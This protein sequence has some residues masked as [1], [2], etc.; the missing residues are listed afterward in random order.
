MIK[1]DIVE[2]LVKN[3]DIPRSQAMRAVEGTF[4]AMA[5]SLAKGESIQVRGFATLEVRTAKEKK[6][7]DISK[8]TEVIVPTHKTVKIKIS[9]ELKA[10]MNK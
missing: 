10:K 7:R 8:G 3:C 4:D 6:A 5:S 9:K 2:Y 1:T